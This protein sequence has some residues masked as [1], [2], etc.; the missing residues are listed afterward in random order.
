[1]MLLVVQTGKLAEYVPSPVEP[2]LRLHKLKSSPTATLKLRLLQSRNSHRLTIRTII[3]LEDCR[4]HVKNHSRSV[5][6]PCA[7]P[8]STSP[9]DLLSLSPLWTNILTS[10]QPA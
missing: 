8:L 10:F 1:M 9:Q 2:R 5:S 6:L 7:H 3:L 4:Q